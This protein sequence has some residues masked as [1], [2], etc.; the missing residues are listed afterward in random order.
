VDPLIS[1]LKRFKELRYFIEELGSL[2]IQAYAD[3]M[4]LVVNSEE[5]IQKLINHAKSFFDFANIKLNLGKYEIMKM[6]GEKDD[7]EIIID[8]VEKKYLTHNSFLKYLVY[9]WEQKE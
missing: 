8:G 9:Q 7:L 6:N 4:I 1:Y 5:N 3:D 2:V